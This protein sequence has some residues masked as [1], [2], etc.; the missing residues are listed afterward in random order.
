[1]KK[2]HG[3]E[4]PHVAAGLNNLAG[5]LRDQGKLDEAEPLFKEAVA[6]NKKVHGDE[7]PNVAAGIWNF[8]ALVVQQ[9]DRTEATRLWQQALAIYEKALG[10]DHP[11]TVQCRG[12]GAAL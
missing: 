10:V 5:L 4:H 2:V 8:A 12:W 11:T 7:H 9:G 1:M 3:D 6:V